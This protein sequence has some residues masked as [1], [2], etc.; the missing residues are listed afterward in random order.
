MV[1]SAGVLYG[2]QSHVWNATRININI[3][4]A[5]RPEESTQ[6]FLTLGKERLL[7]EQ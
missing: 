7:Y 4:Y 2:A 5:Q 1:H 3:V 6:S